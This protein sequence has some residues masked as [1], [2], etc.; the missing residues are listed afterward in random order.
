METP[1]CPSCLMPDEVRQTG[2]R[3]AFEYQ[4]EPGAESPVPVN[5]DRICNWSCSRCGSTFET[6]SNDPA[7]SSVETDGLPPDVE[8]ES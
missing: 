8:M 5:E 3:Y 2:S 7:L 1:L 6:H 4:V